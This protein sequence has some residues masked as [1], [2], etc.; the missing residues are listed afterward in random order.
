[1][2]SSIQL[3]LAAGVM[4]SGSV[5]AETCGQLGLGDEALRAL[6]AAPA[7]ARPV[8]LDLLQAEFQST[9]E[10]KDSLVAL[11]GPQLDRALLTREPTAFRSRLA[12]ELAPLC[13]LA[14]LVAAPVA[15]TGNGSEAPGQISDPPGSAESKMFE[16]ATRGAKPGEKTAD[17]LNELSEAGRIA[18]AS[19]STLA[20]SR[21]RRRD[22]LGERSGDDT[23]QFADFEHQ[24]FV[25]EN[26][27]RPEETRRICGDPEDSRNRREGV[28][29]R[30]EAILN[31]VDTA[32]PDLPESNSLRCSERLF[33]ETSQRFAVIQAAHERAE[34]V[35]ADAPQTQE[36]A[37]LRA[38]AEPLFQRSASV[39]AHRVASY[40]LYAGPSFQ[41]AD[42]GGWKGGTEILF[43]QQTEI[44]QPG[45]LHCLSNFLSWCRG[46]FEASFTTPDEFPTE[47]ESDSGVPVE[48]FDSK[49]RLRIEGGWIGHINDWAGIEVGGGFASPLSDSS[50]FSRAE[51]RGKLGIHLQTLHN[52]GM[53]GQLSFGV[54][55]DRSRVYLRGTD[56]PDT[57]AVELPVPVESFD[58]FYLDAT[59][60]FPKIELGGWRLAARL[61]G[62]WP[63]DG[64]EQADVRVS[65]L[66][67]YPF[68]SWLETFRP[69]LQPANP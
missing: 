33:R 55:H 58:R 18:F 60:L 24:T 22:D 67:Y 16:S 6:L 9:P 51:Y 44:F 15:P 26:L 12:D 2:K 68:N 54:L 69:K 38:H 62:D 5:A 63:I 31:E 56:N 45:R 23:A 65:A 4:S 59:A 41:L 21:E 20:V 3:L 53:L 49:G 10:A 52:D 48:I 13:Q 46:Y 42:D 43:K 25:H 66:F 11:L 61:S 29:A 1:M 19:N 7:A 57:S 64:N 32:C 47:V 28:S 17:L 8:L 27:M 37:R 39:E 50:G 30:C 14:A 36:L 34:N 35:S 40:G